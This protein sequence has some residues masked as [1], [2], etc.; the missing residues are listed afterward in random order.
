MRVSKSRTSASTY[1]CAYP[2][3][4]EEVDIG[5]RSSLIDLLCTSSMLF[6]RGS[7]VSA[8]ADTSLTPASPCA[9]ELNISGCSSL[10]DL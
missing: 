2:R 7:S 8:A 6:A 5:G 4:V 1:I 3:L 9:S 10:I